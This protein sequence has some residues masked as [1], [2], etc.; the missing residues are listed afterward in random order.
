LVEQVE[1]HEATGPIAED[2]SAPVPECFATSDICCEI[3]NDFVVLR[4]R[5]QEI[6]TMNITIDA[7][8]DHVGG[9][10]KRLCFNCGDSSI[11][12]VNSGSGVNAANGPTGYLRLLCF[13]ECVGINGTD[14]SIEAGVGHDVEVNEPEGF[15]SQVGQLLRDVRTQATQPNDCDGRGAEPVLAFLAE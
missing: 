7:P 10:Q 15:N 5:I 1:A 3:D 12:N 14:Q 11:D 13:V 2:D 9:C 4:S 8:E 6:K